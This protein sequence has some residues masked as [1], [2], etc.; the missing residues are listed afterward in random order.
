MKCERCLSLCGEVAEYRVRTDVMDIKVCRKCADEA[1][2]IGL[3]VTPL[4]KPAEPTEK[5]SRSARPNRNQGGSFLSSDRRARQRQSGKGVG[6]ASPEAQRLFA[7]RR[8][9]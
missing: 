9:G 3:V 5:E 6:R 8:L 2:A 7:R 1:R 4:S